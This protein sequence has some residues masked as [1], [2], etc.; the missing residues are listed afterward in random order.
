VIDVFVARTV[1]YHHALVER[2]C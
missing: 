2:A 1:N